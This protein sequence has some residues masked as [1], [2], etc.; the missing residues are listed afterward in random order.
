LRER[1]PL[2]RDID[3]AWRAW[4]ASAGTAGVV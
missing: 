3:E 1:L 4:E 2:Y